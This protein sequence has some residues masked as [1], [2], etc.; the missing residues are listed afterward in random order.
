ML[1][2]KYV[3]H[4][5]TQF[6]VGQLGAKIVAAAHVDRDITWDVA[7]PAIRC[8]LGDVGR[9]SARRALAGLGVHVQVVGPVV[10]VVAQAQG[11]YFTGV[12]G[13]VSV[14]EGYVAYRGG[15]GVGKA[16]VGGQAVKARVQ[17]RQVVMGRRFDPFVLG[18]T[19]VGPAYGVA[20]VLQFIREVD[21]EER[22]LAAPHI[23][24]V[25]RAQF[26]G[27]GFFRV[28]AVGCLVT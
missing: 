26:V 11:R 2:V 12:Q 25:A 15:L 10:D 5:H 28:Q 4:A 13:Q 1:L 14:F 8:A 6:E 23:V 18:G 24:V 3:L 17:V 16:R 22:Q 9:A 20:D 19:Q 27:L 7:I 21:V